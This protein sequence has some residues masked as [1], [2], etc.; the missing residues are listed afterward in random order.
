M[1]SKTARPKPTQSTSDPVRTADTAV[2]KKNGGGVCD[3]EVK[4][5]NLFPSN[6]ISE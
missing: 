6:S 3:G 4:I 1:D 5:P 2:K